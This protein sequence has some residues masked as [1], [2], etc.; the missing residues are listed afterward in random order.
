MTVDFWTTA[1]VFYESIV[2]AIGILAA[3]LLLVL[4]YIRMYARR[5]KN[6]WTLIVLVMMI[7]PLG[8]AA[9]GYN[10]YDLY[11]EKG[12]L[13]T[14]LI[15]DRERG[16]FG[17]KYYT[18][19]QRDLYK[20]YNDAEGLR[21]LDFYKEETVT[22]PLDFLGSGPHF[23]YFQDQNDK[24]FKLTR[25]VEFVPTITETQA[26]GSKFVLTDTEFEE[27]GFFNPSRV[28]FDRIEVPQSMEGLEYEPEYDPLIPQAEDA[29]LQWSF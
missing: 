29:W 8:Y 16:L 24:I 10:H 1:E 15:R 4:F 5:K 18:R 9:W 14:P 17:Y 2:P 7:L 21:Q 28:M 22:A 25:G 27:I 13:A 11:L 6:F 20:G 19:R 23:H 3:F 26:I 12:S